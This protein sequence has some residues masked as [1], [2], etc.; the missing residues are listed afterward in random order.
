MG[1]VAKE[2]KRKVICRYCKKTG[3]EERD[4]FKKQRENNNNGKTRCKICKKD[5]H[6]D[7]D[8]WFRKE[9]K[10]CGRFKNKNRASH[11]RKNKVRTIET[12]KENAENPDV[13]SDYSEEEDDWL[14]VIN[15]INDHG[16]GSVKSPC[17]EI[18]VN[19][20]G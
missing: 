12:N 5:N 19:N 15:K 11:N 17:V 18:K 2:C 1:H 9:C 14:R 4:C 6:D 7:K 20:K 10:Y 8:C 3:H 16:P 13:N